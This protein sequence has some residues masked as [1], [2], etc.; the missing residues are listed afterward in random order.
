MLTETSGRG[1]QDL[2][3]ELEGLRD[4]D[5]ASVWAGTPQGGSPEFREWC[6]RYGRAAEENGEVLDLG[7]ETWPAYLAAAVGVLNTPA[8]TGS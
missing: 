3:A 8:W 2:A 5:W 6:E 1:A 7:A 4:V